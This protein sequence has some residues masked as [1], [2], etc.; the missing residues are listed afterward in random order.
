MY[1]NHII[2]DF[3]MNPVAKENKSIRESLRHEI[4]EMGAVM[5]NE[6]YDVVDK[7]VCYVCP[8]YNKNITSFMTN[9]TGIK[10]SDVY[11]ADTFESALENLSEWIGDQDGTR[12]YSWSDTDLRQLKEE[13]SFKEAEFP[14]NMH[15]WIDLQ[16]IYPRITGL[17]KNREKTALRKAAEQ[18]GLTI[19]TQKVHTALYDAELTSELLIPILTGDYCKQVHLLK[20]ARSEEKQSP[21]P[22]LGDT[23]SLVFKELLKQL[24]PETA[25]A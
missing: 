1:K 12:I 11:K 4:I 2:L 3:E 15:R 21:T 17:S 23:Y 8:Q 25:Q 7:F 24:Q 14:K 13:C 16:A 6:N 22:T 18:F 9:L 10:T 19:D 20:E 5:L